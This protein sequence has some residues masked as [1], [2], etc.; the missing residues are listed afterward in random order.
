MP[1]IEDEELKMNLESE[2]IQGE[3][4]SAMLTE[5]HRWEHKEVSLTS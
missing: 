5:G 1:F 2:S 3:G 4:G